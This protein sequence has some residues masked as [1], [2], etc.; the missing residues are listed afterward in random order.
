VRLG[1]LGEFKLIDRIKQQAGLNPDV[2]RG[3]GDDAAELKI[4]A[5]HHLLTSTDLL[6]EE[7]HFRFAWTDGER[8][9]RKA[10]AVNLSDLAAMGATPRFLYLGLSCP[11]DSELERVEGLLRGVLAECER[12]GV[13]LV[14]GDTCC[15]PGPWI[16]SVVVE[17]SAPDGR[18]VGRNGGRPDDLLMVS[19]TLGD[20]ALGLSLLQKG[21]VV[22]PLLLQRHLAPTPRVALGQALASAGLASAMIDISDG[23]AADLGHLLRAGR[24]DAELDLASLPLS[25][26]FAGQYRSNPSLID[27]ALHGGEDYELLF[28]VAEDAAPTVERLAAELAVPVSRIGRLKAGSG[29][30]DLREADGQLHPVTADGFDHFASRVGDQP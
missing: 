20:S 6:I 14:G 17:G 1:E 18:S 30:I 28:S 2:I 19:G 26:E 15:S 21:K 29:A 27:L 5:G 11:A 7:V 4:P 9:G 22:P 24:L 25:T 3:I 10:V 23:L 8:L 16:L 12:F 13:S